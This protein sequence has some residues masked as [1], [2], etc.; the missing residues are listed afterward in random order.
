MFG[1]MKSCTCAQTSD[2]KQLRRVHYCGTCKIIGRLYRQKSR[3]LLNSDAVFL[4]EVLSAISNSDQRLDQWNRA[5]HSHNCFS[6]PQKPED[7]PL[8]LQFAA[9]AV[10]MI[11][12]FKLADR[13]ADS[14]RG[15][16]KI[17]HWFFSKSFRAAAKRLQ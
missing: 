11:A 5:D 7:M 6:L 2:Q 16:W 1:L 10:L 14:N 4:G 15:L 12:E 17:P 9:T 3:V 8:A 13:I